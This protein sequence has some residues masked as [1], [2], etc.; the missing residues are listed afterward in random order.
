MTLILF[1]FR[2]IIFSKK[3]NLL[4]LLLIFCIAFLFIRNYSLQSHINNQEKQI[5]ESNLKHVYTN[6]QYHE[7][8]IKTRPED[9]KEKE[10]MGMSNLM[11]EALFDVRSAGDTSDWQAKL[12]A[13]NTFL[14][15]AID[16]IE[17]GGYFPTTDKELKKNLAMNQRLLAEKI[18]P[19]HDE[20]SI[21][22]P[23]FMKQVIDLYKNFG[24]FIF[25][26]LLVGEILTSEFEQHTIKFLFTQPIKR[27]AVMASKLFTSIILYLFTSGVLMLTAAIIG[28]LFGEKG[29]YHYPVMSQKNNAIHFLYM[30]EYITQTLII[31]TATILMITVLY[32]LYSL[33]FKHILLAAFALLG[34]LLAGFALTKMILLDA[35]TW[36]NPFQYLIWEEKTMLQ[37][38]YWYSGI[39]VLFLFTGILYLLSLQKIKSVESS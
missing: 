2:K 29:T 31:L 27:S 25:M 28:Y 14:T 32:L 38:Y 20:Y 17:F 5:I 1:E 24:A 16:Y 10:L 8:G 12:I 13:E 39:P 21:A 35:F 22:A 26:F 4:M 6:I 23:N 19:Q 36:F 9:I 34:T 15:R 37:N 18:E 11:K 7:I 30:H 33:L 3:F